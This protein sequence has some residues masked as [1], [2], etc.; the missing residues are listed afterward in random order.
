MLLDNLTFLLSNFPHLHPS[1]K[2]FL[3]AVGDPGKI[4]LTFDDGPDA[5]STPWFLQ[6]LDEAGIKATFFM[7]GSM[8]QAFP[9]VVQQ[10]IEAG[11]EIGIHGYSH[12]VYIFKTQK[13]LLYDIA[14]AKGILGDMWGQEPKWF[15]PP[16]GLIS[17]KVYNCALQTG[18]EPI[19]W[20][21]W[22]RDWK[23][24][25][26]TYEVLQIA[27]HNLAPG[28]T[29]LLHDSDCTSARGSWKT[30]LDALVILT[31]FFKS[32]GYDMTTLSNHLK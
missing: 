3:S 19:L 2:S 26:T 23:I 14:K 6:A 22:G 27:T 10:V 7:L 31:K 17:K 28:A 32:L 21:N 15:R 24:G 18:L 25:R 30:S 5:E 12:E 13:S 1:S 16:Y 4:C 20:T 9:E 11:H 29:I 8:A